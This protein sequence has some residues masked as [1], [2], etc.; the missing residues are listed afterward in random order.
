[1]IFLCNFFEFIMF[2]LDE[3]LSNDQTWNNTLL[4]SKSIYTESQYKA[5]NS[6]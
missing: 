4:L 3:I 2:C 5:A 1:M 6:V